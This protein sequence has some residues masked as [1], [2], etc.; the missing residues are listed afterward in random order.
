MQF[1]KRARDAIRALQRS[2]AQRFFFSLGGFLGG[3]DG[4]YVPERV[5]TMILRR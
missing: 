2:P 3:V 4:G 1:A 5:V